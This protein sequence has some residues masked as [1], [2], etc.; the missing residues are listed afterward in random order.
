MAVMLAGRP[1][2]ESGRLWLGK[3]L[4]WDHY[5][6]ERGNQYFTGFVQTCARTLSGG[7]P[8]GS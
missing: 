1:G 4:G 6:F 8:S 2:P 3:G 5:Q 7:Q